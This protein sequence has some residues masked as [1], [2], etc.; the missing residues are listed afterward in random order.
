MKSQQIKRGP[1]IPDWL[2]TTLSLVSVMFSCVVLL[3]FEFLESINKNSA[4]SEVS[5]ATLRKEVER[6]AMR[7]E[8]RLDA[9]D[10]SL[11]GQVRV[12]TTGVNSILDQQSARWLEITADGQ[13]R[14]KAD[15]EHDRRLKNLESFKYK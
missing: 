11:T 6:L 10:T 8:S 1:W 14:A 2:K 15:K 3:R 7:V 13:E 12:L 5:L 9:L 4:S